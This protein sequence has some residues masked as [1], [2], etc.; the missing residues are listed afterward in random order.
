MK[1]FAAIP[2]ALAAFALFNVA[3][4]QKLGEQCFANTACQDSS[5]C[6]SGYCGGLYAACTEQTAQ[7]DCRA[8]CKSWTDVDKSFR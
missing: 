4:A 8:G 7:T 6:S 1:P 2:Y 5:K 3:F